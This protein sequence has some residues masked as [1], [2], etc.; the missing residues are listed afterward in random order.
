MKAEENVETNF[1]VKNSDDGS[2]IELVDN[3]EMTNDFKQN[4][5][6]PYFKDIYKVL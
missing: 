1:Y 5:C 3:V 2:T 4:V 6:L